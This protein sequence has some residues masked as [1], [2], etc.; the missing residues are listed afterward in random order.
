MSNEHRSGD[1]TVRFY[2]IDCS[3]R[4]LPTHRRISIVR[5]Q[6]AELY[7]EL[8]E[9]NSPN[10]NF[11]RTKLPR[12]VVF[13]FKETKERDFCRTILISTLH[14]PHCELYT[15]LHFQLLNGYYSL[16]RLTYPLTTTKIGWNGIPSF[17]LFLI[18]PINAFR[19]CQVDLLILLH[20]ERTLRMSF[21]SKLRKRTQQT[22]FNCG[23]EFSSG[24][25]IEFS[26]NYANGLISAEDTGD[27]VEILRQR[28]LYTL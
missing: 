6:N 5:E 27:L 7:I 13:R 24:Y 1:Q 23:S 26:N 17:R 16:G 28:F 18:K 15:G 21:E 2:G 10:S 25:L 20:R 8:A 14:Q 19:Q 4:T 11:Y 12:R 22:N 3:S 9:L